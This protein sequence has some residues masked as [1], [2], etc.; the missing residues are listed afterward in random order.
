MMFLLLKLMG[1]FPDRI[2]YSKAS[3]MG[4]CNL[5]KILSLLSFLS[6]KFL[7]IIL[8]L[9][10]CINIVENREKKRVV[11]REII[12]FQHSALLSC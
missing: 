9:K 3:L 6:S 8:V 1:I 5:K 11:S 12:Y 7:I 2:N 10:V 4:A